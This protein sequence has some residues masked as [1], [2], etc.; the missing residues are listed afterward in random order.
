MLFAWHM[1]SR[2]CEVQRVAE[3]FLSLNFERVGVGAQASLC[4]LALSQSPA[5][6]VLMA[7]RSPRRV[8]REMCNLTLV[9]A[10]QSWP[11]MHMLGCCCTER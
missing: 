2:V 10:T 7:A 3:C 11:Y 1:S 6:N 4:G 8:W 9:S 5:N